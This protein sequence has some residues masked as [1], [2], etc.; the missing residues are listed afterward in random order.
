MTI[1]TAKGHNLHFPVAPSPS[2]GGLGWGLK[3]QDY[4][5]W[6]YISDK[7]K[8]C[9]IFPEHVQGRSYRMPETEKHRRPIV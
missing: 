4:A 6:Q 3:S 9:L 8:K 2:G 1:Y 5:R 7:W